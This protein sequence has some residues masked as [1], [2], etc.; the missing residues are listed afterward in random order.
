M[1]WRVWLAVLIMSCAV[2]AVLTLAIVSGLQ[3]PAAQPPTVQPPTV[4]Y[5]AHCDTTGHYR[6]VVTDSPAVAD[7]TMHAGYWPIPAD[8]Y[9]QLSDTS[10]T[11]QPGPMD[12]PHN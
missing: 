3:Q 2:S 7:D 8:Y 12:T 6:L 9:R 11:C 1:H 10:P 4:Y 5:L